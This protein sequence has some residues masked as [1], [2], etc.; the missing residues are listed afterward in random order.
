MRDTDVVNRIQELCGERNWSYYRL[1]R[2]AG[3]PTSTLYNLNDRTNVPTLPI[4][5][6][7][8]D[9]LGISLSEFF[10]CPK[11]STFTPTH[12]QMELIS[13]YS[14][15]SK[16]EKELLLAYAKGMARLVS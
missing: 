6:Q 12:D 16:D 9:A 8:C 7:V 15:L 4:L 5:Q 2:E 10:R 13:A 1:A 3:L 14:Q 11:E